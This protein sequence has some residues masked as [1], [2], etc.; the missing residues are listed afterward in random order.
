MAIMTAIVATSAIVGMALSIQLLERISPASR[1][2]NHRYRIRTRVSL[3]AI[4]LGSL[5]I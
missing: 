3:M 1:S 4:S 5:L 2:E